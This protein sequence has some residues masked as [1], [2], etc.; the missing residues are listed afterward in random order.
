MEQRNFGLDL[1]R[2]ISIYLVLFQHSSIEITRLEPFRIGIIG[3]EVFFVLSGFL[4]GGILF[5]EIDKG[6][7]FG[8]T[9]KNFLLRRWLR[10][11]PLYYA[12]LIANI[13][14]EKQHLGA[15]IVAYFFFF[16]RKFS[17]AGFFPVSWSL[18]VEEW[19]YFIAPVFLILLCRYFIDKRKVLFGIV[20]FI[21]MVFVLRTLYVI[22]NG[23]EVASFAR[24]KGYPQLRFDSLFCGILLAFIKHR[25]FAVYSRLQSP[26]IFLTGL[27]LVFGYAFTFYMQV[28]RGSLFLQGIPPTIGFLFFSA[29]VGLMLPFVETIR[30]PAQ[31]NRVS[32]LAYRFITRTSILTYGIYLVH[33]FVYR[34][35]T[36]KGYLGGQIQAFI[37]GFVHSDRLSFLFLFVLTIAVVYLVAWIAYRLIEKPALDLREVITSRSFMKNK[38]RSG[39]KHPK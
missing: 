12:A 39:R 10:T 4:I 7:S 13:L 21:L 15:K 6:N 3:V 20:I 28:Y 29:A 19:F 27:L 36:G 9:Y 25:G 17:I 11:L 5:R 1:V 14:L 22:H 8:F 30:I 26:W 35:F 24:M 23:P 16:Q 32:R 18:V 38:E 2:A 31:K 34:L 33:P 37:R